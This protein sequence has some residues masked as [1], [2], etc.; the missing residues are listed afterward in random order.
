MFQLFLVGRRLK[1]AAAE[2]EKYFALDV[3]CGCFDPKLD[4]FLHRH[5]LEEPVTLVGFELLDQAGHDP[6]LFVERLG[7]SEDRLEGE[8]KLTKVLVGFHPRVLI[9]SVTNVDALIRELVFFEHGI[10][11]VVAGF[12]R[13]HRSG[14][15]LLFEIL[16]AAIY[17]SITAAAAAPIGGGVGGT[18]STLRSKSL[19]V[20]FLLLLDLLPTAAEGMPDLVLHL[21]V[22]YGDP[23]LGAATV[24]TVSGRLLALLEEPVSRSGKNP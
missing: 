16:G 24:L 6:G 19:L 17:L 23:H 4:V 1:W 21:V 13:R 20:V 7:C 8:D 5:Q 2:N 11:A 15:T 12:I 22:L 10:A 3:F 9:P 14:R 18:S